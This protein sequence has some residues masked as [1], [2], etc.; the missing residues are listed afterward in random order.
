MKKAVVLK[1]VEF[2]GPS[3]IATLLAERECAIDTRSLYRGDPVPT[4]LSQDQLLIV[5]GGPMGVADLEGAQ[6]PF[7]KRELELLRNCIAI[8]SPVLAVC[9]GAQLLAHAAGARV[10]PMKQG[11]QRQYEVGWGATDFHHESGD[12]ALAGV[13]PRATLLHWHGDTFDLPRG[14][15]LLASTDV[16]KHQ[17]Y[18][19]GQRSFGLQFHCET[20]AEDVEAWIAA[21]NGFMTAAN[22]EGAADAM[23]R[24]TA[25]YS[26]EQRSVGDT[27]LRNMI[28]QMLST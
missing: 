27:L 2:E 14:A 19:L 16:C 28:G 24:D 5:M 15:Q 22:G 20:S 18:R 10:Y 3:R 4:R 23:R 21:D 9:L 1:H 11:E 26:A 25:R 17:A 8:G 7:L 12:R 13:P 6:F